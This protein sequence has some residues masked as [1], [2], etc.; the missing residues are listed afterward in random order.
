[1][2]KS[3]TALRCIRAHGEEALGVLAAEG[4]VRQPALVGV[5]LLR[6]EELAPLDLT[7]A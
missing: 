1:M 6:V 5:N 3:P 2:P 4:A 7:G